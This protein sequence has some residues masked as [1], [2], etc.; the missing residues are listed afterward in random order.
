MVN[1]DLN[2][3][4]S[5]NRI[6][7]GFFGRRNSGKSSLINAFTGQEVSIVS[8]QAGTTT[9]PVTKPME[10]KGLGPCVLIDTAGFDDV[11]V[12]GGQRIAKS[13]LTAQKADIAVILISVA[14]IA[15]S[16]QP[17]DLSLEKE[18]A[19]Y[20]ES[21][22]CRVLWVLSQSDVV[23]PEVLPRLREVAASLL[24]ASPL[25][26]SVKEKESL[27]AFKAALKASLAPT[28]RRHI[29]GNLVKPRDLVVLVMPQDIQAP[30]GRLI[31]P[32]VQTIRELLDRR[33][34]AVATTADDFSDT[35]KALGRNPD[36]IVTDSQVFGK[37]YAAKPAEV[38]LTSF[39]VLFANYKGDLP[40]YLQGADKLDELT[41]KDR[42]L[43]AECCSHAPLKEDIG[44]EK[45]P[46]LLRKRLGEGIAIDIVSGQDFPEDLT[47]YSLIIQCGACMFNRNYVI[48]RIKRAKDQGVPMSNYGV[49][50]AK[51][52]GILDQIALNM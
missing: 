45:L 49:I 43:I 24:Q 7:I 33:C 50:L 29:L 20:L 6:H 41:E 36:L 32:Q 9:D 52:N 46:R 19:D 23:A 13:R 31:L 47:P 10:I 26:V 8:A 35:L 12:L 14:Y 39:S 30:Q 11:G 28:E 25:C 34:V 21:Q 22:N 17:P 1:A 3:T 16:S 4:P 40:Y 48:N 27:E 51:L 2:A 5:A 42:I 18:W 44:R 38:P 15:R 37:V